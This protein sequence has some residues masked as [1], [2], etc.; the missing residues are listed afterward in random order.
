M[1]H[2]EID[3]QPFPRGALLGAAALISVALLAAAAGRLAGTVTAETATAAPV[4]V[5]ELWFRD[6]GDGAVFVYDAR[7]QRLVQVL[8]PGSNGFLR[9]VLRGLAR[10]RR[11]Q[12][13]GPQPPFR[14]TRWDDGALSLEDLATGRRIDLQ[15][16]GPT[17][18]EAFARLLTARAE[19]L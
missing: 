11:R 14:L 10:E 17:N 15:A 19:A 9:G 2:R 3:S 7:D 16:F 6:R 13:L 18:A 5:R 8:A 4:Q 12:D 1:V